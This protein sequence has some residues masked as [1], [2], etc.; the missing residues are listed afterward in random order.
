MRQNRQGDREKGRRRRCCP[1]LLYRPV[2]HLSPFL[3]LAAPRH[4]PRRHHLCSP[5]TEQPPRRQLPPTVIVVGRAGTCGSGGE[6]RISNLPDDQLCLVLRWLDTHTAVATG[7]LLFSS[8]LPLG[9]SS[10]SPFLSSFLASEEAQL[11]QWRGWVRRHG[12]RP[13]QGD[14]GWPSA[15]AA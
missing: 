1:Q 2:R 11:V 6:D 5:P 14:G 15:A 10:C 4:T 9:F 3:N 13:D 7:A 12:R 8:P